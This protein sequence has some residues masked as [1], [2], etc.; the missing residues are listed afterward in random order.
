[1][2]AVILAAG[3]SSRFQPFS[4][5]EHKSLFPLFGKPLL[6]HTLETFKQAN[7]N[8]VVIVVGE[9]GN[10]PEAIQPISG[11]RVTFVTQKE[12]LGMGNALSVAEPHLEENF[13]LLSGY[14][15]DFSDFA[16]A[17]VQKQKKT[18]GIV[19]LA[20]ED[21]LL[22]KYGVIETDKDR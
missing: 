11:L 19:L 6:Q 9:G 7:I 18:K 3:K 10:I 8:S 16:G 13:F 12:K 21:T 14:H 4:F 15:V 2:Q 5:L 20:K 17:M 1:M 22:E